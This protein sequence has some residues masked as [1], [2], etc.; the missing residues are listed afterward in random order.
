MIVLF[1]FTSNEDFILDKENRLQMVQSQEYLVT[2]Q[3][4]NN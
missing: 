3:R 4:I 2:F 1:V